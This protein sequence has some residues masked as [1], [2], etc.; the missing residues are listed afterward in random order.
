MTSKRSAQGAPR[1]VAVG[2]GGEEHADRGIALLDGGGA[3]VVDD[4]EQE[5]RGVGA[6]VNR[7]VLFHADQVTEGMEETESHG[8]TEE[9]RT[10]GEEWLFFSVVRLCCSVSPCESVPSVRLRSFSYPNM[11]LTRSNRFRSSCSSSPRARGSN[12]SLG[13]ALASSSI[14]FF[15]IKAPDL[16]MLEDA[17]DKAVAAV[18]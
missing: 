17:R 12:L 18:R 15:C 1:L 6:D 8:A 11:S 16:K 10:N 5:V 14:N 13:S 9:Q 7:R 4:R 3:E 2:G